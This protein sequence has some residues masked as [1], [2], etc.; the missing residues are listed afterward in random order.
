MPQSISLKFPIEE[1]FQN[2]SL[3]R[4]TTPNDAIRASVI[5]FLLTEKGQR[6]GNPVGSFLP[7]LVHR[8]VPV[9]TLPSLSEELKKEL[10]QQ[11]PG[12]LFSEVTIT[13]S[14]SD[15]VSS[16]KVTIAFS[17]AITDITQF[18]LTLGR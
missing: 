11:F 17:T 7:S 14:F 4:T 8:L 9:G 2:K 16:L 13:Q 5:S 15:N 10:Q 1:D 12:V 3:A 6:R 18:T